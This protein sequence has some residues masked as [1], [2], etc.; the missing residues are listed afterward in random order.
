MAI[1][2]RDVIRITRGRQAFLVSTGSRHG[3]R[4]HSRAVDCFC[5]YDVLGAHRCAALNVR[6]PKLGSIRSLGLLV[7]SLRPF[8]PLTCA[9][10][11]VATPVNV[12]WLVNLILAV[13]AV[14][15]HHVATSFTTSPFRNPGSHLPRPSS[16][17]VPLGALLLSGWI[18]SRTSPS[19]KFGAPRSCCSAHSSPHARETPGGDGDGGGYLKDVEHAGLLRR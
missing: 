1:S 6:P 13:S 15:L 12:T 10:G 5:R 11:N 17:S 16:S 2:S 19:R 8:F 7:S 9:F 14:T 18:F 4:C 3:P